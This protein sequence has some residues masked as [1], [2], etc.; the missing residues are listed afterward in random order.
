MRARLGGILAIASILTC[1]VG[2]CKTAG[3]SA[4]YMT[5][6]SGGLQRRNIFY[7]DSSSIYCVTKVSAARPDVT[8][9]FTI[10]QTGV[11]PWC[12]ALAHPGAAVTQQSALLPVFAVAEQAPGVGV[13]TVVTAQLLMTGIQI[14][15][16]CVG[17][18][19]MNLPST[20]FCDQADS[21]ASGEVAAGCESGYQSLGANSCGMGLTCC[22][23]ENPSASGSASST[24][25]ASEVPYPAGQYTCIVYM[26][27]V[28]V[29]ETPFSIE[30][31]AGNES[32]SEGSAGCGRIP[33]SSCYCPVPP[34]V[35]GIPCYGW[36]PQGAQC[37][38]YVGGT[39]CTCMPT[40]NWSCLS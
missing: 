3:V 38:G 21:G 13:E 36:V 9:D 22:E 40:G 30:Y 15:T 16:N 5:I 19:A 33:A 27:G 35:D 6:D 8:I 32:P 26:D 20:S 1:A 10:R 2:A 17:Y 25:A 11:Y 34:P 18:C 14:Q 4:V 7:T 31:P 23:D 29:G 12:D 24:S 39:T 28:D 37:P